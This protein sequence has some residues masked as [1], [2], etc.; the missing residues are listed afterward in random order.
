MPKI[1]NEEVDKALINLAAQATPEALTQLR[2]EYGVTFDPTGKLV[3]VREPKRLRKAVREQLEEAQEPTSSE[4]LKRLKAGASKTGEVLMYSVVDA[5]VEGAKTVK[6]VTKAAASNT[7]ERFAE[8]HQRRLANA[9]QRRQARLLRKE[10][11]KAAKEA[12]E[13]TPEQA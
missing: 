9:E 12:Q 2:E 7:R 3:E 5:P 1:T 8:N 13:E 6:A 4:T 11:R 10:Q